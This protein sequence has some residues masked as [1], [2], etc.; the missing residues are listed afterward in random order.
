[1][2]SLFRPHERITIHWLLKASSFSLS[3]K[4]TQY[5]VDIHFCSSIHSDWPVARPELLELS[6]SIA[7]NGWSIW[8]YSGHTPED[9]TLEVGEEGRATSG[10]GLRK[11]SFTYKKNMKV[12]L[13]S[14]MARWYKFNTLKTMMH[15]VLVQWLVTEISCAPKSWMSES[16]RLS[17][18][19]SFGTQDGNSI[20][21][22]GRANSLST[23]RPAPV[24]SISPV[25]NNQIAFSK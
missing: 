4:P 20:A 2:G 5:N 24:D 17:P 7:S 1:M 22:S 9:D 6:S 3:T 15:N 13:I 18:N 16:L 23:K 19:W 14:I 11:N 12:S 25:N 21:T 8:R 10:T